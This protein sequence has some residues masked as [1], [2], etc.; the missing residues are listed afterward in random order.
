MRRADG[1]LR[2][3]SARAEPVYDE[4]GRPTGLWGF[5]QDITDLAR[6]ERRQRMVADL[7]RAALAGCPGSRS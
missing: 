1:E 3:L 6:A 2:L 5:V 7:G 4:E